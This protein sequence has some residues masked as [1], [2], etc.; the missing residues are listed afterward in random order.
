MSD[1]EFQYIFTKFDLDADGI[2]S[3]RDFLDSAG[4]ECFPKEGLFFRQD[5][6]IKARGKEK[7]CAQAYCC[8][9]CLGLTEYCAV[10][11]KLHREKG[12][13]IFMKVK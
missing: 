12:L 1:E 9:S 4:P 7:V 11:L 13:E 2:I 8:V 10:H 5:I 6:S 3:Y